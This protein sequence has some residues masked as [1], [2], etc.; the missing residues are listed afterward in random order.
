MRRLRNKVVVIGGTRG[1]PCRSFAEE[2]AKVAIFNINT[3]AAERTVSSITSAGGAA[4]AFAGG[5]I[6]YVAY[7]SGVHA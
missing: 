6:G 1:A 2:G 7:I 3:A 5:I 4:R